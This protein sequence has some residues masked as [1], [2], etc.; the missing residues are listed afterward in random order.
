MAKVEC[1]IPALTL[2]HF[3][4]GRFVLAEYRRLCC[5]VRTHHFAGV[6]GELAF[7]R[8]LTLSAIKR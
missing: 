1:H 5:G 8:G 3:R 7:V 4:N 2:L 6:S